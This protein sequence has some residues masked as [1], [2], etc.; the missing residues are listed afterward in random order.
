MSSKKRIIENNNII[1]NSTNNKTIRMIE[2]MAWAIFG[3]N[4]LLILD[5]PTPA[6]GAKPTAT[7]R[8]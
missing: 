4:L 7:M 1:L 3:F 8:A 6:K 5:N 2:T